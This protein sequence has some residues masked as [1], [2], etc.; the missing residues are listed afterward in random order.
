[1]IVEMTDEPTTAGTA[2]AS[3]LDSEALARVTTAVA[4]LIAGVPADGWAEPTPCLD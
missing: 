2:G 1:M 4:E 3:H